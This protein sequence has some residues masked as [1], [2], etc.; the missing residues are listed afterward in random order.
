MGGHEDALDL[1]SDACAAIGGSP[2]ERQALAVYWRQRVS[3]A[4][5]RGVAKVIKAR[6]PVCT[7][8]R[9]SRITSPIN[10]PFRPRCSV[11]L[12]HTSRRCRLL[13]RVPHLA[14]L[15]LCPLFVCRAH[16]HCTLR[17][18]VMR[19]RLLLVQR[20]ILMTRV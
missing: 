18:R 4:N 14:S 9:C 1:L 17:V 16:P 2:G 13:R 12:H 3:V 8:I 5:A 7:I 6:T 20:V 11:G 10:R 19:R 15:L